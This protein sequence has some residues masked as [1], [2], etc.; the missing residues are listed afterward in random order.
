MPI[1]AKP[2]RMGILDFDVTWKSVPD[3]I[4]ERPLGMRLVIFPHFAPAP[5]PVAIEIVHAWNHSPLSR[6]RSSRKQDRKLE[7]RDRVHIR[8][9]FV[10]HR[11]NT[12]IDTRNNVGG[13]VFCFLT[14]V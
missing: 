9:V 2:F 7:I 14:Q 4:A 6:E 10:F 5:G 11:R 3:A 13:K 12:S 8:L 1:P